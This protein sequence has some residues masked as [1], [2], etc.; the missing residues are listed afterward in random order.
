M[1]STSADE[2]K[3]EEIYDTDACTGEDPDPSL[4]DLGFDRLRSFH[5]L[6]KPILS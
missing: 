5:L 3:I 2:K 6:F 4:I 1:R